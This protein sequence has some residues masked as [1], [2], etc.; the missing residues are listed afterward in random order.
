M[1][2]RHDPKRGVIFM[3]AACALFTAMGV[4]VKELAGRVSFLEQ[5]F[6]RSAFALPVVMLIVLRRIGLR[7]DLAGTLRTKRFPGHVLRALSGTAAQGCSFYALGL[8]PLA[9]HTALTNTTPL[10]VT[11]LS[12]PLLGEKVGIHRSGAVVAG[13]LGILVIALGQGAF[14]GDYSGAAHW[15]M[16]AALAHG[17]FSAGT[18][19]L[20]RTLSDTESSGTIVLWQSLLMT[21]F[22]LFWL[23]F[24]WVTPGPF[25]LALLIAIGLIGGLAQVLLTEAWASAQVSFLAPYSYSSLLWAV[26]FGWAVFGDVP[27]LSTLAGAAA[28]V[29]ASLYIMHREMVRRGTRR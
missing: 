28:I 18:T 24:V 17:M 21:L 7:G 15:G 20:V 14:T 27:G 9:E 4:L 1:A 26:L 12:I 22:S 11:L 10:F 19:M 5:M 3:L 29:L 13:F 25:D 8:L 16:V 2:L 6:F 23:P